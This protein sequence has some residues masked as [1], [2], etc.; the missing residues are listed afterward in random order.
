V[1]PRRYVPRLSDR[2]LDEVL[3]GLPA[4]L[5]AGP[6]AT[7]KTT[8]ARRHAQ[9]VV[10]LD[11]VA[12][13]TA[14]ATDP[15]A[16][17]AGLDEPVLLDEWQVV[18]EVL[19]AVK[20][21]VDDEARPGRFILTG[22][23]RSD[24]LAGGWPATGRI[25]RF[26]HWGMCRRELDGDVARPAFFDLVFGGRIADLAAPTSPPTVREY[27][28]HALAGG[29][30]EAVLQS[31]PNARRRWLAG[32]IDQL[33]TR[34][35]ALF[36]ERRDPRRLRRYLQALAANTAGIVE[37]KSLYDAA[38][39]TRMTALAYDGLLDLL[40]VTQQIPAWSTNRLTRLARSPKR[41]LVD[42]SLLVPLLG[43]DARA[44][45]RDGD[46]LGRIIDSFVVAQLRPEQEVSEIAPTLHHLR[47]EHGR[48]EIDLIVE[49]PDGRVIGIEIKAGAAP[50]RAA[51]QHLI[52]LR[53]RL[54]DRF[55]NGI[56][57]H[58]GPR[59]FVVD[60]RIHALPIAALWGSLGT[61]RTVR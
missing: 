2:L 17:L 3:S 24:A 16:M 12:E 57:F 51:A 27:V 15:D 8:T 59:P 1:V 18:P 4:V 55:V 38:G 50:D 60:D 47:D 26:T 43:I 31:S 39:I 34:D 53:D 46:L 42:P 7:G 11:R 41:Y 19:G 48:H 36:D 33:L 20:R 30:P 49:A 9:A 45:L 29:F 23:A 10:R 22:S 52:W 6:R 44:A 61:G 14:F 5:L 21:A 32:Y 28:E 40:M 35:A 13:A 56:V 37:H 58:T 54:G 25:V